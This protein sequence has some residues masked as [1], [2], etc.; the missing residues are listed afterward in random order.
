M[1]GHYLLNNSFSSGTFPELY[2][3]GRFSLVIMPLYATTHAQIY[4]LCLY[5]LLLCVYICYFQDQEVF[6]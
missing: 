1:L 3:G 4:C 2:A 6:T 5:V